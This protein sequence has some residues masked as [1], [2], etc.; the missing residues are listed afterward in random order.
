MLIRRKTSRVSHARGFTLIEVLIVIAIIVALAGLVGVALFSKQK[1]AKIGLCQ[2]DMGSLKAALKTFRLK[3][4][5]W[6]TDD[7]GLEAL[8]NVEKLQDEGDKAKWTKELESPLPNDRWGTAWGYR[9]VSEH[10]DTDTF[11]LWSFGPD[12]EEGTPDDIVSWI[13]D[14]SET[15]SSSAPSGESTK[16]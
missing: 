3:F 10:G 15:G 4:D 7:E 13:K 9:Q 1:D 6:P 11:D 8:W 16:K 14:D 5:R 12:K 2:A